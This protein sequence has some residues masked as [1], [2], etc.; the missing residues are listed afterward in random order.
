MADK[1]KPKYE[2]HEMLVMLALS[3]FGALAVTPGSVVAQLDAQGSRTRFTEE[4]MELF[5]DSIVRKGG[6]VK[7][8]AG[9]YRITPE[10]T[11]DLGPITERSISSFDEFDA[12]LVIRTAEGVPQ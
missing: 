6:A 3:K 12:D 2:M 8:A 4:N 11:S 10:G 1:P 5:L 9:G 7:E